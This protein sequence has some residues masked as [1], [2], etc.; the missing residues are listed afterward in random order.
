M[1]TLVGCTPGADAPKAVAPAPSAAE[2]RSLL[3]TNGGRVDEISHGRAVV[4]INVTPLVMRTAPTP[5]PDDLGLTTIV[6]ACVLAKE[7]G[8]P[9][10][11]AVGVMP[12][13]EITPA[14]RARAE[15]GEYQTLL[16]PNCEP[17][18]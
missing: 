4:M 13:D 9:R 8:G 7:S 10:G 6:A 5:G 17:P 16:D 12:T 14:V 15:A 18:E 1:S 2:L 11:F 3:G